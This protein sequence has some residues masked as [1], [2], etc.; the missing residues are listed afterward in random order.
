VIGLPSPEVLDAISAQ[1]GGPGGIVIVAVAV[2]ELPPA[3]LAVAVKAARGCS[4]VARAPRSR[5]AHR[6]SRSGRSRG[7]IVGVDRL[8]L[9]LGVCKRPPSSLLDKL[10]SGVLVGER[11][12]RRVLGEHRPRGPSR[13]FC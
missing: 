13:N 8:L 6:A 2:F 3:R 4:S 11:L 12:G 1:V 5:T 10:I 7:A 9:P